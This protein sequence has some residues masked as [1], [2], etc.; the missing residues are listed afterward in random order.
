MDRGISLIVIPQ[1]TCPAA[2]LSSIHIPSDFL[3]S[4]ILRNTSERPLIGFRL[5]WVTTFPSR[6]P[7]RLGAP[8]N[9]RGAI[10]PGNTCTIPAQ[11]ASPDDLREGALQMALFVAEVFFIGEKPWK[12]DLAEIKEHPRSAL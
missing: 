5:G 3:H 1:P 12:A 9:L 8:V 11:V 7:V 4:A 6:R 10:E 2:L